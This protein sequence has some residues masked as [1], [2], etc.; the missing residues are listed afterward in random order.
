MWNLST[1]TPVMSWSLDTT[2][3]ELGTTITSMCLKDTHVI[4]GARYCVIGSDC[5]H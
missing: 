2:G 5:C 4:V 1:Q 3:I